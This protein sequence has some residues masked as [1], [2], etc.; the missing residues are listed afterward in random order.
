MAALLRLQVPE[1]PGRRMYMSPSAI[2][3]VPL[4]GKGKISCMEWLLPMSKDIKGLRTLFIRLF[5][6]KP[7]P[8]H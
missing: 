8:R 4:S 3:Y 1:R 5:R 2:C 6:E 7:L